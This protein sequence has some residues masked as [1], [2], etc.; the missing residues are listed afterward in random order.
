MTFKFVTLITW[1][2]VNRLQMHRHTYERT[3]VGRYD[4]SFSKHV[5]TMSTAISIQ[6]KLKMVEQ[7]ALLIILAILL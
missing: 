6:N 7:E 3:G 4:P 5:G 2:R 1:E